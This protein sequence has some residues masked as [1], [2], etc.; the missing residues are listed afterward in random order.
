MYLSILQYEV[1]S[2]KKII[3]RIIKGSNPY[4]LTLKF[5]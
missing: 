1:E 2:L 5:I 3:Q 4:K